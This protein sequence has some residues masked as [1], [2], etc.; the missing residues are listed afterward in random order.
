MITEQEKEQAIE[1]QNW[2]MVCTNND[3]Y[4]APELLN[5]CLAGIAINHPSRPN[6]PKWNCVT[7]TI[8]KADGKY[9]KTNSGSVYKLGEPMR[10]FAEYILMQNPNW[11]KDDPFKKKKQP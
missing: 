1:L 8:S 6:K 4:T 10:E 9:V 11:D 3:G 2:S 7:S 5:F